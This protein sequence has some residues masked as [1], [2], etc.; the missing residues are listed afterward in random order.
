[1][2]DSADAPPKSPQNTSASHPSPWTTDT[3]SFQTV[4]TWFPLF[5][6]SRGRLIMIWVMSL[7]LRSSWFAR[8]YI[9]QCS[10]FDE[11]DT[12]WASPN[13]NLPSILS[14]SKWSI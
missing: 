6:I 2:G 4:E 11:A 14:V 9:S 3:S 1:M 10:Y 5:F 13:P 7:G 12:H 8:G